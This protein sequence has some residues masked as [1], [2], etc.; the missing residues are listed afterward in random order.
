MTT[1]VAR[2]ECVFVR[3][4][5]KEKVGLDFPGLREKVAGLAGVLLSSSQRDGLQTGTELLES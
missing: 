1:P 5:T 2:C 4:A 3:I